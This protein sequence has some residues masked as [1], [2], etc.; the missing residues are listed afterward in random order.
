MQ[1]NQRDY[2]RLQDATENV[3]T[4]DVWDKKKGGTEM[5]SKFLTPEAEP[6]GTAH[7]WLPTM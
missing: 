3:M 6:K 1:S 7:R 2:P 4:V 5:P